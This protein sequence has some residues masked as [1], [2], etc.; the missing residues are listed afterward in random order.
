MAYTD[1]ETVR[2]RH[3]FYWEETFSGKNAASETLRLMHTA[4]GIIRII[5]NGALLVE[6][7]DY[8]FT[9]TKKIDLDVDGKA[10]DVF[11]VTYAT[12]LLDD[13]IDDAI[14]EAEQEVKSIMIRRYGDVVI[15]AWETSTPLRIAHITAKLAG[16]I[17]KGFLLDK[18][19][20][21]QTPALMQNDR[22]IEKIMKKLRDIDLGRSE[23]IGEVPTGDS[24]ITVGEP[25]NLIYG[26]LTDLQK[27]N[28]PEI[29]EYLDDRGWEP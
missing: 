20:V 13:L 10:S 16:H 23:I 7:T 17:A 26:D 11:D 4:Y 28:I 21:S 12:K 14:E 8:T 24:E 29:E 9:S 18:G 2:L 25:T 3:G 1:R 15:G 6:N 22:A 27:K 19:Q 5:K